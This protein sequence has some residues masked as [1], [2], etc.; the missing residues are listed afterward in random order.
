MRTLN[1]LLTAMILIPGAT[2]A[3][4]D[5][6]TYVHAPFT[7]V[8]RKPS[9]AP[10]PKVVVRAPFVHIVVP[11]DD[12]YEV[13]GPATVEELS[14]G[15]EASQREAAPGEEVAPPVPSDNFLDDPSASPETIPAPG[16]ALEGNPSPPMAHEE[17]A[18]TMSQFVRTFRPFPGRHQATVIHPRTGV[19]V[20]FLFTL[21]HDEFEEIECEGDS[22]EI[23]FDDYEVEIIF[24]RDGLVRVEYDD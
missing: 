20:T 21:P 2:T 1:V 3:P 18:F 6:G 10:G 5:D 22:I 15:P 24:T 8:Y 19:P 4:A 13:F 7:R 11:D 23:D 16:A 12:Y 14:S 17:V 9:G